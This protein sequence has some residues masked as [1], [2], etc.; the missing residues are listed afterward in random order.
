MKKGLVTAGIASLVLVPIIVVAGVVF[1]LTLPNIYMAQAR[2]A[3]NKDRPVDSLDSSTGQCQTYDPNF[4]REQFEVLQS[5][6]VRDGVINRLNLR[7]EWSKNGELLRREVALKIL[8]NSMTVIQERDTSLIRIV[9]RRPDPDEAARIANETAEVYRDFRLEEESK[10]RKVRL[11][12]MDDALKAQSERVLEAEKQV[13]A[14]RKYYIGSEYVED[15]QIKQVKADQLST[16]RVCDETSA[17]LEKLKNL[18]SMTRENMI[19]VAGQFPDNQFLN[20]L[21]KRREEI[22]LKI[23]E[24]DDAFGPNHPERLRYINQQV[25]IDKSLKERLSSLCNRIK[26]EHEVA[27]HRRDQLD[28]RLVQLTQAQGLDAQMR[29]DPEY[30]NAIANLENE[31]SIYDQ[32][33][34]RLKQEMILMDVPSHLVEI[35]D[36]AETVRR[37]VSPN[38]FLNTVLACLVASVLGLVGIVLLAVGLTKRA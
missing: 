19:E 34:K 35:I 1:T 3:V 29:K 27:Q 33:Y 14:V 16:E 9:C 28:E 20:S 38:L 22:T 2:I 17:Q 25:Q 5:D 23:K 7:Q 15:A 18:A 11:E 4:L 13:Y 10:K 12:K 36:V 6:A 37:P 21:L 30:R 24:L 31:R 8:A 32:L 26:T